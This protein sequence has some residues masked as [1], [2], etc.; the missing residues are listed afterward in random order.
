MLPITSPKSSSV[1]TAEN[2]PEAEPA[3]AGGGIAVPSAGGGVASGGISSAK[4]GTA[5]T[6]AMATAD[7]DTKRFI[8]T[9]FELDA[10]RT[11]ERLLAYFFA[12][13]FTRIC[14][15]WSVVPRAGFFLTIGAGQP[16]AHRHAAFG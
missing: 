6:A 2:M 16:L 10:W 3:A 7:T 1:V 5:N 11:A 14:R 8:K 13:D 12:R 15:R 9:P 4:A